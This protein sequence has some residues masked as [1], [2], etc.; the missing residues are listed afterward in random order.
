MNGSRLSASGFI[1]STEQIWITFS[2][3]LKNFIFSKVKDEM[4]AEDILQDVFIKIHL[5]KDKLRDPSRLSSWIY[6]IT[7]NAINDY[8]KKN[9]YSDDIEP[10]TLEDSSEEIE[11]FISKADVECM[12]TCIKPFIERLPEDEKNL[13][14]DS[15]FR[16]IPQKEIAENLGLPYSTVKSK[17]QRIRRKVKETLVDCCNIELNNKQEIV[18]VNC[19]KCD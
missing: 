11:N 17:I 12:H 15:D 5:Y 2:D 14:I 6:T 4:Q 16:Q 8:F 18:E 1:M 3:R 10:D 19:V 9:R 7:R 13:L